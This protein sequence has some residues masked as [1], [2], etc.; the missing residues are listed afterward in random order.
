MFT[1]KRPQSQ[2]LLEDELVHA[3]KTLRSHET[4]SEKYVKTLES[5]IKIHEMLDKKSSSVSK[6]T[7]TSVGANLLGIFMIIKHESVN[8]ITS[9]ALSF[10]HRPR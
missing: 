7:L 6:E 1:R 9:K 3:L 2:L 10:V 5:I 8:V 4:G